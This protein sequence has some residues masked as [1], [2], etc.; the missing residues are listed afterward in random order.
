MPSKSLIYSF[1]T[2]SI[3]D[4]DGNVYKT[5]RIGDQWWMTENLK[6]AHYRNGIPVFY[7]QRLTNKEWEELEKGAFCYL[8]NS[9]IPYNGLLYNWYAIVDKNGISPEGWRVP[10]D[11]DWKELEQ[12]LGMNPD[13]IDLTGWR[14]TH[15][16]EKLKSPSTKNTSIFWTIDQ[17]I[18]NTNESGF[19]AMPG[20]FRLFNGSYGHS[21]PNSTGTSTGFW[22]SSSVNGNGQVWYRYLDY[23]YGGVFRFYAPK[24]SGFSIRCV[25]D[26]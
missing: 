17:S 23:K 14:G 3:T 26:N 18:K 15:E 7:S 1:E 9:S 20:G 4:V 11:D 8:N 24:S 22:W 13:T 10:T 25:K 6:V 5:V 12:F 2:D 21:G 19:S 16:G